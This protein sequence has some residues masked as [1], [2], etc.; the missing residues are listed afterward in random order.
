MDIIDETIQ[1]VKIGET[2]GTDKGM[3]IPTILLTIVIITTVCLGVW[4]LICHYQIE[5]NIQGKKGRIK[6]NI[7]EM[8]VPGVLMLIVIVVGVLFWHSKP[9][10]KEVPEYTITINDTVTAK[11]FFDTYELQSIDGDTYI[12]RDKGWESND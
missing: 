12:V 11:E 1:Y 7:W 4:D 8:I 5:Q 3:L 2:W 6:Q 10:Y 9:V